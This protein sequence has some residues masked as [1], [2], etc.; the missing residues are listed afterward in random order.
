MGKLERECAEIE[1]QT[2]EVRR[3]KTAA[4]EDL[5]NLQNQIQGKINTLLRLLK[6]MLLMANVVKETWHDGPFT[7]PLY[8]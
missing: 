7:H 6:L 5:R 1:T 8:R 3:E 4:V 2:K